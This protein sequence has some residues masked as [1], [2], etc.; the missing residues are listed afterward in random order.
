[1]MTL[2]PAVSFP[3]SLEWECAVHYHILCVIQK[4]VLSCD[5]NA[6][7][8]TRAGLIR[9][10][11]GP[12][13]AVMLLDEEHPSHLI[14]HKLLDRLSNQR[15]EVRDLR[16]F[17]RLANPLHCLFNETDP[18]NQF[19]PTDDRWRLV[20]TLGKVLIKTDSNDHLF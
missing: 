19:V 13:G 2:L 20:S 15:I 16:S 12:T 10:L 14:A 4:L 5:R 7:I 3:H 18:V 6:Q 1:M 9:V 17:L 11:I 8:L